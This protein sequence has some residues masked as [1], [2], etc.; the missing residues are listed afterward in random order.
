MALSSG[1]ETSLSISDQGDNQHNDSSVDISLGQD[2]DGN[3]RPQIEVGVP[4][5]GTHNRRSIALT[6]EPSTYRPYMAAILAEA[7]SFLDVAAL[8][9]DNDLT[10]DWLP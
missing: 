3:L 6:D 5:L 10:P 9:I 4:Q 1:L 7:V 8:P 2:A